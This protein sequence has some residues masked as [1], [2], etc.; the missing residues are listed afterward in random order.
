[1]LRM[2]P[3]T[4]FLVTYPAD[5]D[6]SDVL[7]GV[8]N[9]TAVPQ[10]RQMGRIGRLMWESRTL[11]SV[12]RGFRP[13]VLLGLGDRAIPDPPC[14]Q[15]VLLH[16]SQMFYP[17][18]F[19]G[20]QTLKH[21][22]LF[23]YHTHHLKKNLKH[24]D[25]L[26]CQTDAARKRVRST[27]G[28]EGP[29]ELCPNAVSAFTMASGE[30]PE[31]PQPLRGLEERMKLFCLTKYYPHKNLESIPKLFEEHGEELRDVA[32][33]TTVTGGEYPQADRF[34][35]AIEQPA[36]RDHVLN[37]GYLDQSQLA[38]YFHHCQAMFLPTFLE[39]FSGTYV[40]AMHF[41]TPILTS[42]LDFAH[43][44]CG[45]AAV[46]F[47][48]WDSGSIRGAVSRL[49][50]EPGLTEKLADAG[51]RRLED[52]FRSWEEIASDVLQNLAAIAK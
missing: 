13:D 52:L 32:V 23:R 20:P 35:E 9:A 7:G 11:P 31:C 10:R 22:L 24:V 40:E 28:Y 17:P 36:V 50:D 30:Q 26:F 46:Y 43:A 12:L 1:M 48:P 44:V 5:K 42:D 2:A 16:R 29:I 21:R 38:G 41:G 49:R 47:D 25:L 34:L 27:F 15:A 37:V 33:V 8:G 6:Y 4:Q 51:K 3:D 39:S 18:K 45:E 14:P 19:Y